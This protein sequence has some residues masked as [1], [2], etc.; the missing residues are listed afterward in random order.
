MEE[1]IFLAQ[2]LCFT[3]QR[4]F[5]PQSKANQLQ[6]EN[7]SPIVKEFILNGSVPNPCPYFCGRE[8]ELVLLHE[9]LSQERKI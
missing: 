3:M 1:A 5:H 8:E 6:M 7:L 9:R 2:V 4:E